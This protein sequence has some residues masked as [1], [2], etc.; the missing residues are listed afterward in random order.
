MFL[1]KHRALAE[2]QK[3]DAGSTARAFILLAST[4]HFEI[5]GLTV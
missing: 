1:H 5:L 2:C 3:A 4:P